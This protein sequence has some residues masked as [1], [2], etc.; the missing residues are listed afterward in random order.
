MKREKRIWGEIC[1]ATGL[2]ENS[3][4]E[5]YQIIEDVKSKM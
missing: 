4:K 2:G 3:A 5:E 1:M